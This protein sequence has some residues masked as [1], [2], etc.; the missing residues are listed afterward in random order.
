MAR[1]SAV[2]LLTTEI[3]DYTAVEIL[4]AESLYT[5]LYD[6][7]PINV[8][9]KYW[10]S[11]GEFDKYQRTTYPSQKPADNLCKKLNKLFFTDKFTTKKIL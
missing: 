7:Q 6:D 8:K 2:I 4:Q 9:N 11:R 3:D 5:V 1:P 10:S